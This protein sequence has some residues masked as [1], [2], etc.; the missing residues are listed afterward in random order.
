MAK[1]ATKRA[2]TPAPRATREQL[3]AARVPVQPVS[4]GGIRVRVVEGRIGYYDHS[5]RR[6][7]DVFTIR[8]MQDFSEKWMELVDA[9]TPERLTTAKAAL[10]Q[11]TA[12]IRG[13]NRADAA[14]DKGGEDVLGD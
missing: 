14:A 13:D 6:E 5:R 1:R 2:A 3:T 7:G 9:K 12:R 10:A 4:H 8:D 11:A